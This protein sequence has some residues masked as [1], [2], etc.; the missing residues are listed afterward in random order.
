MCRKPFYYTRPKLI[1]TYLPHLAPAKGARSCFVSLFGGIRINPGTLAYPIY[2]GPMLI[3]PIL[4]SWL[5]GNS[6][7]YFRLDS[8]TSLWRTWTSWIDLQFFQIKWVQA[9]TD[10][11]EFYI[12]IWKWFKFDSSSCMYNIQTAIGRNGTN[13]VSESGVNICRVQIE[14]WFFLLLPHH[15]FFAAWSLY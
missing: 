10:F 14:Q 3:L 9:F 4:F 6:P 8:T 1:E 13:S 7:R 11:V 2:L 5:L 15:V 12:L